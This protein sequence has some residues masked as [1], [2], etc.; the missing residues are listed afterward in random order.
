MNNRNIVDG[1]RT[2][3]RITKQRAEKLYNGGACIAICAGNLRPGGPWFPEMWTT[4]DGLKWSNLQEFRRLVDHFT[5]HN[6]INSQTGYYPA[7]YTLGNTD[8]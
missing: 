4:K 3:I 6:C 2:Y 8:K 7:F 1:T 5:R